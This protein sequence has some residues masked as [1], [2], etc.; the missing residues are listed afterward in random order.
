M[1]QPFKYM[2][3]QAFIIGQVQELSKAIDM[4]VDVL[5]AILDDIKNTTITDGWVEEQLKQFYIDVLKA[6]IKL[7]II[8][9]GRIR[10]V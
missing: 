9:D 2:R 7:R 6:A 10:S 3:G 1:A 4:P 5:I 8:L